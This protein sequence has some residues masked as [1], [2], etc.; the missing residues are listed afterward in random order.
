MIAVKDVEYADAPTLEDYASIAEIGAQSCVYMLGKWWGCEQIDAWLGQSAGGPSVMHSARV[1]LSDDIYWSMVGSDGLQFGS[2][3]DGNIRLSKHVGSIIYMYSVRYQDTHVSAMS[4][5]SFK[6]V[7]I[8]GD[9]DG[10]FAPLRIDR[11]AL[12]P[13]VAQAGAVWDG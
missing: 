4:S 9:M 1:F 10:G 12:V 2:T 5:S 13:G 8:M 6:G 11:Y 3:D 7:I